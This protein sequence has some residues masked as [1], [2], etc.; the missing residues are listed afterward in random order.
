MAT[1]CVGWSNDRNNGK[2]PIQERAGLWHD[3][4]R[5]EELAAKWR[6]IQVRK[7]H[8]HTSHGIHYV[9]Q[10]RCITRLIRP[11]LKVH[12]LGGAYADQ[13]SYE[14]LMGRP[15]CQ[16][17]VQAVATLFDS[18]KV[19]TRRVRDRLQEGLHYVSIGPGNCRVLVNP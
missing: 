19:E 15:L 13:D 1:F 11:C 3:Q 17:G 10:W 2:T 7:R 18:R 8:R 16:R 12:G 9:G 14:F 4:V 5:L 6:R